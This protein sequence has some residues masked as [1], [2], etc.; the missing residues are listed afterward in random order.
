MSLSSFDFGG[1]RPDTYLWLKLNIL[2]GSEQMILKSNCIAL[3]RCQAGG[4]IHM[5]ILEAVRKGV[6]EKW[7]ER[8]ASGSQAA[9]RLSETHGLASQR[10]NLSL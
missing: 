6:P 1:K 7:R 3:Q 10:R 4:S 2:G 8:V 5:E 9:L